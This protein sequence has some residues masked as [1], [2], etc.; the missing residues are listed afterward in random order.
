MN[1]ATILTAPA[2]TQHNLD[3]LQRE[4]KASVV[5]HNWHPGR[6]TIPGV[7]HLTCMHPDDLRAA[8]CDDFIERGWHLQP[9]AMPHRASAVAPGQRGH[10]HTSLALHVCTLCLLIGV[11]VGTTDMLNGPGEDD[12][13]QAIAQQVMEARW[14]ARMQARFDAAAQ[15]ACGDTNAG[16]YMTGPATIQCTTKHGRKTMVAEV[17]P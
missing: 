5:F 17:Q 12:A 10:V 6:D 9:A 8:G 11:A 4:F 7:L 1:P 3:A 14:Q 2:G 16:W 13:A 15:R